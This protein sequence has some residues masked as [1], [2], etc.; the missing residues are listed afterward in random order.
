MKAAWIKRGGLAL[1]AVLVLAFAVRAVSFGLP[2]APAAVREYYQDETGAP[3][4]SEMDSYFYVRL[5]REM[6]EAGKS[7]LYNQREADPLMGSRPAEP[8]YQPV[9]V[10]LSV[11]TFWVWRILH[12]FSEVTVLQVARWMGPVVGSLTAVPAFLYVRQRTN[13]AGGL[14]AGL[15]A[16]LA[17]PFVAHT[18]AGFFD[19]DMLLGVLPLGAVLAELR[20]MRERRLGRQVMFAAASGGL[21]AVLSLVWLTFYTYF[22]LMAL[23]G[24]LGLALAAACPMGYSARR[25]GQVLR[26]WLLCLGFS[27]LGV[28]LLRGVTGLQTLG[29]ILSVFGSVS[30]SSNDFP[31]A[32][33]YTE[34]MGAIPYLPDVGSQGVLSLLQGSIDTVLGCLGGVIPCVMAAV[35][36]ILGPGKAL[37]RRQEPA[38]RHDAMIAALLELGMLLLW[39]AAGVKL[40]GP[41]RRFA[42][43]AVLPLTVLAG[44]GVG[45]LAGL[46]SGRRAWRRTAGAVLAMAAFLPMG[47]GALQMTLRVGPSVTDAQQAAMDYIRDTQPQDAVIGAWWDD[48]Y[49]MQYA[50]RRRTV[51][52]GGTSSGVM[53]YFL[54]KALLSRDPGQLRG[55][56]RMLETS[57]TQA[58]GYLT[59]CGAA[60]PQAAKLLLEAA[61]LDREAAGTLA[62]ETL[63]LT[64]EQAAGLL[65]LTHPLEKRPMVLVL[66]SDLFAKL[67]AITYYGYWDLE[68]HTV[69]DTCYWLSTGSAFALPA[70][71]KVRSA[72]TDASITLTVEERDGVLQA[73]LDK[74]GIPYRLSG[75]Q[76]WRDGALIQNTKLSGNGPT[77]LLLEEADR[78]F[79]F[80]FSPNLADSMLVRLF[81]CGSGQEA[82]LDLLDTWYG[83]DNQ[84]AIGP[85]RRMAVSNRLSW[86]VQVWR[87][88]E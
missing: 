61:S 2:G 86:G 46:A 75:V 10:F 7:F 69:A 12:A 27:L 39:L 18:Y 43:I 37:R 3:Y 62:R 35:F 70:G 57:G 55:I 65:D 71:G 87:M 83:P 1:L 33:Q 47:L 32:H 50:A 58:V 11:L 25:R 53:N 66:G 78:L 76:V 51:A 59:R 77:V 23:G 41:S 36:L 5:S 13:L 80:A 22:W 9:P 21:L 68:T 45:E 19:T 24:F 63:G 81:L 85:E 67:S 73:A 72:L 64:P 17:I 84:K 8:Q 34:E 16:G 26:G 82:G 15:L 28:F 29:Q 38:A 6:A 49:Y 14:A 54:S 31:F 30:G 40:S 48:G 56:F 79:G 88:E 4:L 60:Q 44:L 52:D 74:N 20:A 42:E